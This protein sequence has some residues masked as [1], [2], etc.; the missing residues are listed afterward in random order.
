MSLSSFSLSNGY[1]SLAAECVYSPD[2]YP[3]KEVD[4]YERRIR[5][6]G[7]KALELACGAARHLVPLVKRGL[8]VEGSDASADA[9]RYARLAAEK[10]GVAPVFYHQS[11]EDLDLPNRYETIF[12]VNGSFEILSD[13]TLAMDALQRIHDHL[14][15][16][17]QILIDLGIPS[18]VIGRDYGKP[19]G[20]RRTWKPFSRPFEK[21]NIHVQVWTEYLDSFNQKLI[22]KRQYD[23]VVD[24]EVVQTE[25]HSMR[26]TWYY[27]YEFTLMLEKIGFRKIRFY[28][29]G[30]DEPPI[31]SCSEFCCAADRP[32]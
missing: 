21:G 31:D 24:G 4:F 26:L 2:S 9:L 14:V 29:A 16:G 17:G 30:S 25:I 19:L 12:I 27:K 7:G 8:E 18:E 13:R 10:N 11:M 20:T 6:K 15:P 22:D 32:A 3:R 23:L 5:E 28:A 1:D